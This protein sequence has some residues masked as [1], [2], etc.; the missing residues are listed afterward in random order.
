MSLNFASSAA[1][2]QRFVESH[3]DKKAGASLAP[4]QSGKL[5]LF[6]DDLSQPQADPYGT[7]PA[8]ALLRQLVDMRQLYLDDGKFLPYEV[9]ST[10]YVACSTL[11][12]GVAAESLSD[13]LLGNFSAF[14][15]PAM[16]PGFNRLHHS[17]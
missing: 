5:L 9:E 4:P 6:L 14:A 16:A 2:V 7:V 12:D 1:S 11:G 8:H 10:R 17:G 13:R 3:L 15:M